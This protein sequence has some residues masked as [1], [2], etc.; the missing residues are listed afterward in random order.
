MGRMC[1]DKHSVTAK[2]NK[3]QNYIDKLRADQDARRYS[4]FGTVSE[5]QTWVF[6]F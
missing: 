6:I 2:T 3:K 5:E 4:L 1:A